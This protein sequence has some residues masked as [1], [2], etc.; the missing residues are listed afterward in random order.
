MESKNKHGKRTKDLEK[1]YLIMSTSKKTFL[2]LLL[3]I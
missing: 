3:S 1:I 2:K